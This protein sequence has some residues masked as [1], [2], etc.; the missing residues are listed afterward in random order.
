MPRGRPG[1]ASVLRP[2]GTL[3]PVREQLGKTGLQVVP[4][5]AGSGEAI[6][7]V[8][9]SDRDDGVQLARHGFDPGA[10]LQPG[11]AC[12]P[13]LIAVEDAGGLRASDLSAAATRVRGID[14]AAA[15]VDHPPQGAPSSRDPLAE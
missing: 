14:E 3:S 11:V 1:V 4:D 8:Q 13:K 9:L 15:I 2:D 5:L 10:R 7:P 6:E 12:E